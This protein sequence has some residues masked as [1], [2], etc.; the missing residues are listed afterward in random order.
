LEDKL[1]SQLKKKLFSVSQ[2]LTLLGQPQMLIV[3]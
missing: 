3:I 1:E 2:K